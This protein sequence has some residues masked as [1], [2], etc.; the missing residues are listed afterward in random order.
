M[1][2]VRSGDEVG[3][4]D[5]VAGRYRLV[6][7][8]GSG[9]QGEVWEAVNLR[10]STLRVALKRVRHDSDGES[11]AIQEADALARVRHPNVVSVH[12][13]VEHGG[14]HWIVMD[15]VAGRPLGTDGRVAVED[16]ARYGAQLADGLAAVHAQGLLHRDVTPSNVL[17]AGDRAVLIDFG[18]AHDLARA[19]TVTGSSDAR[20]G[21]DADDADA[22][23]DDGVDAVERG[24]RVSGTRGYLAPEMLAPGA[25]F[26]RS[27]DVFALGATLYRALEGVPPVKD[28]GAR[29]S[30]ARPGKGEVRRP[31]RSGALAPLLLRMLDADPGSRPEMED[32]RDELSALAGVHGPGSVTK[33]YGKRDRRS[34]G[35]TAVVAACVVLLV[36]AGGVSVWRAYGP[37]A[38]GWPWEVR[39]DSVRAGGVA[40]SRAPSAGTPK[41]PTA[42]PSA[43][44]TPTALAPRPSPS[45]AGGEQPDSPPAGTGTGADGGGGSGG[46]DAAAG[47]PLAFP[48]KG[49]PAAQEAS[50]DPCGLLGGGVLAQFG[51]PSIDSDRAEFQTCHATVTSG[52]AVSEVALTMYVDEDP[53]GSGSAQGGGVTLYSS[54]GD[55]ECSREVVFGDDD[56]Y[57]LSFEATAVEGSGPDLCDLADAV[58]EPAAAKAAS[59]G[60]PVRTAL[61]MAGSVIGRNACDLPSSDALRT[62]LAIDDLVSPQREFADWD[63]KWDGDDSRNLRMLFSRVEGYERDGTKVSVPGHVAYVRGDAWDEGCLVD[64]VAR[65]GASREGDGPVAELLRVHLTGESDQDTL[66]DDA[67]TAARSAAAAL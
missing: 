40:P 29:S 67:L 8:L 62:A 54:G 45:P 64:V 12:D 56:R 10:V 42:K 30:G 5:E 22:G 3:A 35:R 27:G 51:D 17:V 57:N 4:G 21:D 65:E 41:E 13:V 6:R 23:A 58:A 53:D 20:S 43:G 33:D 18:I 48:G 37:G 9:G 31:R 25:E 28:D 39:A 24:D 7:K 26:R 49:S 50:W 2:E 36:L 59:G 60:L 38:E 46:A 52:S 55:G 32:V 61:P 66:C 15:F 34:R 1:G 19:V 44:A 47:T 14:D 11:Q 16:A 63:C